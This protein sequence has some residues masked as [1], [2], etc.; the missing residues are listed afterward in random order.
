VRKLFHG[1]LLRGRISN[2][3]EK[4]KH[5]TIRWK[6]LK[7]YIRKNWRFLVK[8]WLKDNLAVVGVWALFLIAFLVSPKLGPYVGFKNGEAVSAVLSRIVGALASILGIV[9]AILLVAFDIMRKT[10]AYYA[11]KEFFEDK[12]FRSMFAIFVSTILISTYALFTMEKIPTARNAVLS[13]LSFFLFTVCMVVLYPCVKRILGTAR[14]K[15]KIRKI[16]G[17]IGGRSISIFRMFRRSVPRPDYFSTIEEDPLFVLSEVAIRTINE[18]DRL[19]PRFILTESTNKLIEL[20]KKRSGHHD[21]RE[22]INSFS[23]IY[24][25]SARQAIIHKQEGTLATVLE[26]IRGIYEFCA[27]K[28]VPW[29]EVIE[30]N[31]LYQEI[32]EDT[33]E[34]GFDEV[35]RQGLWDVKWVLEKQ[36]EKNV[37]PES[38]IWMFHIREKGKTEVP[39]DHDKSLQWDNI[40]HT[41]LRM[42]NSLSE[43][44]IE[45]KRTQVIWAALHNFPDL[46]STVTDMNLG[47]NQKGQIINM[48]SYYGKSLAI[49]CVD[50]GVYGDILVI[51]PFRMFE[52]EKVLGKDAVYSKRVLID[53]CETLIELAQREVFDTF[54]F[55]EIGATGRGLVE[56]LDESPFYKEAVI[57]ICR[58]FDRI[59]EEIEKSRKPEKD[60]AYPEAFKQVE[61]LK[62]WMESKNK[63][64]KAVE[65]EIGS[66]LGKFRELEAYE[67]KTI[68]WPT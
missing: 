67:G 55:N 30:L 46:I 44:V 64:D 43:K 45:F 66:V 28:K 57:L 12:Y 9:V 18:G 42:L 20:L 6:L 65:D 51:T 19:T 22:V 48:C 25:H 3:T 1:T 47:D 14:S 36:L 17:E 49:K 54:A 26:V 5:K 61:S 32:I 8:S 2:M 34:A 40:P 11:V 29:H 7:G 39:V 10:Y 59:R 13:Y 24:R 60:R 21:M 58:T 27:E 63:H 38:E 35:A 23:I 53:F 52:T 41:Y 37:P 4:P 62:R 15:D 31:E 33:I 68:K 16:V 56:K 50:K